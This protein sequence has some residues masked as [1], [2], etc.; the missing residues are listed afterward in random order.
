[1][2]VVSLVAG[3]AI[4]LWAPRS[5]AAQEIRA[6]GMAES[7][8]AAAALQLVIS[9]DVSKALDRLADHQTDEQ[10][11]CL[12]GSREG[13]QVTIDRAEE[14]QI[15]TASR[16]AVRYQPCPRETIALWHT[17]PPISGLRP[18]HLC[19]LSTVDIAA[20]LNRRAPPIQIVQVKSKVRCWWTVVDVRG[21]QN[22][23]VLLALPSQR[24]GK[25]I[26][27]NA[28]DCNGPG[29]VLPLCVARQGSHS[30]AATNSLNGETA[31]A[32]AI[33]P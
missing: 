5:S 24:S 9:P 22:A 25:P 2:K 3:T 12:E 19:Y 27:Q 31:S 13:N 30:V 8:W 10:V 14:P 18:E 29:R 28:V 21:A 23:P 33:R 11:R 16:G 1:M 4:A 17:H 15:I 26:D 20:A 6:A 7:D 32:S